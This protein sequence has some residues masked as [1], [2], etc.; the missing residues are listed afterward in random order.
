MGFYRPQPGRCTASR[1]TIRRR[2]PYN[3]AEALG[4]EDWSD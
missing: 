3:R 2:S 4:E 1:L